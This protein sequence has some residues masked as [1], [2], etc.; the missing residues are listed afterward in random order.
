MGK[1]KK[2]QRHLNYKKIVTLFYLPYIKKMS[3]L[4]KKKEK[5]NKLPND[6]NIKLIKGAKNFILYMKDYI[7]NGGNLNK[8]QFFEFYLVLD[9]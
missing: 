5:F 9:M 1:P 4:T 7:N 3:N 6:L 2:L 8:N